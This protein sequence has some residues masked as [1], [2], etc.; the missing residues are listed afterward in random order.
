[1]GLDM[2]LRKN[3]Y[4]GAKYAHRKVTGVVDIMMDDKRVTIDVNKIY[5]ISEEVGYWR[6]ANAIHKWFVDNVQS[7][8]DDCRSYNVSYD[9]LN[10]LK[11]L[12]LKVLET[13]DPS[14][15]PPQ[16]G[17]FFGSTDIDEDYYQYLQD[18]VRI[19]EELD[20]DCYYQYESSW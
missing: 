14:P 5:E 9:Q 20:S 12:C 16:S 4:I 18:T 6:K 17:F 1:M 13:K 11:N 7:G 2:Y 8:K 3:T 19:I 10:D 15:L